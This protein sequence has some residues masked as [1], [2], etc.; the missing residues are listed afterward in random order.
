MRVSVEVR[1]AVGDDLPAVA[2]LCAEARS[3]STAAA[4]L[5]V[6]DESRLVRQLSVLQA[7]PGGQVLAAFHEGVP[8]G[9]LLVRVLQPAL[10]TDEPSL[11]IEALYVAESSRRRGVGHALLTAAAELA[12][13][14]GAIDVYSVPIP[15]SRGVQRFLARLGFAPAAGHRVVST[16]VLQRRLAADPSSVRRGA[17][18]LEDLIARRRRARTESG[19]VDLR[20]FQDDY[21]RAEEAAAVLEPA[22]L[23]PS[24][25]AVTGPAVTT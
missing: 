12:E 14:S 15:G 16:A 25:P 20:L 3:E 8:V 10:F 21:R 6:A 19:P 2:T 22:P 24:G 4:Q 17:R 18:G 23:S 9:F 1:P 13:Q 7:V 5:C 11:Y